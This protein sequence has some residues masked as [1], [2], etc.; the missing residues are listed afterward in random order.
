MKK[1]LKIVGLS[2][3]QT[4]LGSYIVVLSTKNGNKKVPIIIKSTEAQ[5]IAL[6]IEGIKSPRPTIYDVIRDI[7]N[8]FDL[9]IK[10]VFIYSLLEGIFYTKI[11]ITNGINKSEIECTIGDGLIISLISK[12]PIYTTTE[13]INVAGVIISNIEDEDD[14]EEN[15]DDEDDLDKYI[16]NNNDLSIEEM[17]SMIEEAIKSEDYELAAKLRDKINKIKL[18]K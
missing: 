8:D 16:Y 12:C 7:S 10:E 18:E 13:I 2:Y 3:S 4:Q 17:E 5:I 9:N 15:E 11:I 6:E 1:E 14:L